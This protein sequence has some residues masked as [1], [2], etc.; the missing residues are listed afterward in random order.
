MKRTALL[1]LSPLILSACNL[2]VEPPER[3]QLK[4]TMAG[5]EF[6]TDKADSLKSA[7]ADLF[8]GFIPVFAHTDLFLTREGASYSFSSGSIGTGISTALTVGKYQVEGYGGWAT[9]LGT[10]QMTF[11]IPN[12]QVEIDAAS[13]S[14]KLD[15]NPDCALILVAD[16]FEQLETAYIEGAGNP[17]TQFARQGY[18]W[19]SYFLPMQGYQAHIVKKSGGALVISTADLMPGHKYEVGVTVD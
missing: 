4:I 12:R 7:T 13:T 1:L 11:F 18:F 5:L 14:L 9:P 10:G 6:E 3:V 17:G 8:S 16:L 19:Y 15:A 2:P